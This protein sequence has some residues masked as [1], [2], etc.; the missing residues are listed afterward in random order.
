MIAKFL[1]LGILI[2][3]SLQI[4][5]QCSDPNNFPENDNPC[6]TDVN[7]PIDLSAIGTSHNGTT[8]CAQGANDDPSLDFPN[9]ECSG[10]LDDDAVWYTVYP[11]NFSDG[12]TIYIEPSGVDAI[13][14]NTAVEVYST[15][16]PNG[17]CTG[18][19]IFYSNGRRVSGSIMDFEWIRSK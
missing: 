7:P 19:F 17:G 15:L 14:G 5:A 9:Q 16:D 11:E 4:S 8:C 13:S 2:I 3:Y 18:N 1:Q 10:G 12:F 6:P